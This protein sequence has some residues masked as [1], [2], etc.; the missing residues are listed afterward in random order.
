MID[1]V[2]TWAANDRDLGGNQAELG[3]KWVAVWFHKEIFLEIVYNQKLGKKEG[4]KSKWSRDEGG[5]KKL[6]EV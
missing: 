6:L 1:L 3:L 5:K 4:G 2:E